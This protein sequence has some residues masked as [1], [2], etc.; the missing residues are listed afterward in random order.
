MKIKVLIFQALF[1][2]SICTVNAQAVKKDAEAPQ[3]KMDR[4]TSKTGAFSKFT[5]SKLPN[6]K[7]SYGTPETRIRKVTTDTESVYFYQIEKN[8]QYSNSTASIAYEDLLEV[9]KA[10]KV[11]QTEVDKDA[12]SNPNYLENKFVTVDGFQIGYY[13][14]K[15]KP[16]WYIK[17]EKFGTDNTLFVDEA[18]TL[19]K[20]FDDAKTKIEEL[21]KI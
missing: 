18:T 21:K 12:A 10:V 15:E 4:F 14:S 13:I 5:D 9:I 7:C 16:K 8:A 1:F 20:T 17:L 2:V 6:L 3:T 11:L 19:T